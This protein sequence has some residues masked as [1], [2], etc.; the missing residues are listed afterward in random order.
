M[1]APMRCAVSNRRRVGA[2]VESKVNLIT[3]RMI[4]AIIGRIGNAMRGH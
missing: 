4:S 1:L 3:E 2:R